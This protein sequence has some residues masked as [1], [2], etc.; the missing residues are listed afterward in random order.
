MTSTVDSTVARRTFE[1]QTEEGYLVAVCELVQLAGN[2][3]PYF[4]VT[5]TLWQC[6]RDADAG[7]ERGWISGGCLHD[8]ILSTWPA[9]APLVALHLS[10][11]DGVP[12]HAEANGRYHVEQGD[13]DAA[14]RTLRVDVSALPSPDSFEGVESFRDAFAR[15]VDEQRERWQ[16]EADAGLA[17]LRGTDPIEAVEP[18]SVPAEPYRP[19]V[20]GTV[21]ERDMPGGVEW[22]AQGR[23]REWPHRTWSARLT[24]QGRAATFTY[25][26]GLALDRPTVVDVLACVLDDAATV[27]NC[28]DVDDFAGEMGYDLSE[29]KQAKE[30]ARIWGALQSQTVRLRALLG[31]D[32]RRSVFPD[33]TDEGEGE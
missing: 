7:N 27:E 10:D 5:G 2:A 18:A 31:D 9:L 16:A 24:Y 3:R 20:G 15:F 21:T 33:E 28:A 30:A 32:Y 23:R 17:F 22:T 29:P 14:A 25:K 8:E 26:T 4:S 12:M 19:K 1:A 6:K 11:D 13:Y